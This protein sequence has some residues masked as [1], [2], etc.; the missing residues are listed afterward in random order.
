MEKKG[1]KMVHVIT[2]RQIWGQAEDFTDAMNGIEEN[3]DQFE[4]GDK[5]ALVDFENKQTMFLEVSL[6]VKEY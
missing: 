6:A 1:N 3:L 4:H 2:P 5:I